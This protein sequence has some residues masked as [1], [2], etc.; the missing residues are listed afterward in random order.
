ML[1]RSNVN[2]MHADSSLLTTV[3]MLFFMMMQRTP[4]RK[5]YSKY[6]EQQ[7]GNN[8][9]DMLTFVLQVDCKS[10]QICINGLSNTKHCPEMT[11]KGIKLL[12][13]TQYGMETVHL[14]TRTQAFPLL[15][16]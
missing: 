6:T 15:N 3:S 5:R 1:L 9:V 11:A 16:I 8:P 2:F 12:Q 4:G 14:K 13:T 7:K 10:K